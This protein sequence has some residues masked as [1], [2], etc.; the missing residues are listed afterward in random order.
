MEFAASQRFSSA[1]RFDDESATPPAAGAS[2]EQSASSQQAADAAQHISGR[3]LRAGI[4]QQSP[5]MVNQI[6]ESSSDGG[7]EP[8]RSNVN[9]DGASPVASA[10][11]GVGSATEVSSMPVVDH[12]MGIYLRLRGG[13]GDELAAEDAPSTQSCEEDEMRSAEHG[14]T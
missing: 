7:L 13:M 12:F 1:G 8:K 5:A 3:C 4:L 2:A 11:Q 6:R 14:A 9:I 10:P